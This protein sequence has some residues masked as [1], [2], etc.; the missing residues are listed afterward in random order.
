M[1]VRSPGAPELTVVSRRPGRRRGEERVELSTPRGDRAAGLWCTGPPRPWADLSTADPGILL[2][3]ARRLGPGAAIMVSYHADETERALRRK[4]PPAAT[5]LGLALLRAG[6]RW[7]KDWYFAEGGRE[8]QTKL[9]GE[10]PLDDAHARRAAAALAEELDA[11]LA[12]GA[13]T[14]ADGRR[15]RAARALLADGG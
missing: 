4:V 11:F 3:L 15:A 1:A 7:L 12:S 6:C 13:R 10:L 8:G 5:A 9:Q 2:P 14:P